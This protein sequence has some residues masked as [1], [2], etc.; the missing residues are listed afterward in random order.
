MQK[1]LILIL[2]VSMVVALFALQNTTSV[3][4]QILSYEASIPLVLV[5]LGSAAF[6]A[7]IVFLIDAIHQIVAKRQRKELQQQIQALTKEKEE[8]QKK[9]DQAEKEKAALEQANAIATSPVP[10]Q[11]AETG[12][13]EEV[14]PVAG[15]TDDA[16]S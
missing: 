2:I 12:R 5:I 13:M 15:D 6:G 4:V 7:I 3:V 8:L 1:Q 11:S 16:E 14:N 10:E 9:L